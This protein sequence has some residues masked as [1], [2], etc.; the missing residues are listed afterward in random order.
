MQLHHVHLAD[1][2]RERGGPGGPPARSSR[3]GNGDWGAVIHIGLRSTSAWIGAL[4]FGFALGL[5]VTYVLAD[6][7]RRPV[8][9]RPSDVETTPPKDIDFQRPVGSRIPNNSGMSLASLEMPVSFGDEVEETD[10]P[11]FSRSRTSSG[12]RL[13]V[14]DRLAFF[15]ERFVGA[16]SPGTAS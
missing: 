13:L 15:N 7:G 2:N 10:P 3:G 4:V 16:A 1:G 6:A 5:V 8:S 12:D 11:A 9:A 14:D